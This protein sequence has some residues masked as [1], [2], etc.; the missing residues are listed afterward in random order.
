MFQVLFFLLR[1]LRRDS[2]MLDKYRRWFQL[3]L[4]YTRLYNNVIKANELRRMMTLKTTTSVL[5]GNFLPGRSTSGFHPH[6]S[7][8]RRC[9]TLHSSWELRTESPA[10][11]WQRTHNHLLPP[12]GVRYTG[13]L[14]SEELIHCFYIAIIT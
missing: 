10:A 9:R 2:G 8:R 4:L 7:C 14:H 12:G 11:A 5:C 1:F 13:R 6:S 3:C